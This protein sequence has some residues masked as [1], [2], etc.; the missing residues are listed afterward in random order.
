MQLGM[1]GRSRPV[2]VHAEARRLAAGLIGLDSDDVA[3]CS[4]SSEAYNLAALAL[5]SR[6]GEEAVVTDL[7]S[8]ASVPPF[9]QQACPARVGT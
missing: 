9:L 1:D 7:D 3:I 4:C 6:A 2:T 8:P 5:C